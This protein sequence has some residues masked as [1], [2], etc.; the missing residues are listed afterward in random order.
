DLPAGCLMQDKL[1]FGG[2]LFFRHVPLLGS[3]ADE[4]GATGGAD[5]SHLVEETPNG[6][7]SVGVLLA[8]PGIADGLVNPYF[9]PISIEFVRDDQW[10]CRAAAA[11][12]LGAMGHDGDGTISCDTQENIWSKKNCCIAGSVGQ[13]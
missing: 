1:R 2:A 8:V 9:C 10:K 4:H 6:V 3:R 5:L 11:S 12:H 7:R 13:K